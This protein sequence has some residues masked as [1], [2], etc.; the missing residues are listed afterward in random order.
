M[1]VSNGT[2]D[3]SDKKSAGAAVDL[4]I[5]PDHILA[6]SHVTNFLESG[7]DV[8]VV[9]VYSDTFDPPKL[10][11]YILSIMGEVGIEEENDG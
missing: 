4:K 3:K 7:Y 1:V 11:H 6:G 5:P 2:L 8:Q 10:D 9:R